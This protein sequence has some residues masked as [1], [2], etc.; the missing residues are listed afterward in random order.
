MDRIS[1]GSLGQAT[2]VC[3]KMTTAPKL[4]AYKLIFTCSNNYSVDSVLQ[5]GL[6]TYNPNS[7]AEFE[8][9]QTVLNTC[10]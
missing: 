6:L 4:D 10:Y 8:Q 3:S 9:L 5:S 1:F 2:V 7:A